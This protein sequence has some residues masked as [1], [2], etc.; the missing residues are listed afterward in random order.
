MNTNQTTQELVKP[1]TQKEIDTLHAFY[2]VFSNRDYSVVDT[3][4]ATNWQDIPLAPGQKDGPE[5]YKELVQGF[6]QAFP[7]VSIKIHEIF[8]THE[9]VGVRAEISFTHSSKFMGIAPTQEK[10]TIALHE[11]HHLKDGKVTKTWH[12]ED[13]LSMLIQ[14]GAWPMKSN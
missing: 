12:L 1:L 2:G 13:W 7:D 14:T 8:G 3:I 9:R 11:F 4:L 10:V 5:G 6:A